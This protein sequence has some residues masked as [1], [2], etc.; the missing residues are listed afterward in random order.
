MAFRGVRSSW[1]IDAMKALFIRTLS[2]AR[3]VSSSSKWRVLV[4]VVMSLEIPSCPI[5]SPCSLNTG[6]NVILNTSP[7]RSS[8]L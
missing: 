7:G 5:T 1:V 4:M 2:S 3:R 6:L 8:E